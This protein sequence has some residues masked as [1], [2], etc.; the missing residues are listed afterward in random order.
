LSTS[1]V[2]LVPMMEAVRA[3]TC[4]S[5]VSFSYRHTIKNSSLDAPDSA[6][7]R[8]S[9]P[10][11]PRP[12]SWKLTRLM[13]RGTSSAPLAG[14]INTAF[15][16]AARLSPTVVRVCLRELRRPPLA[17]LS[18]ALCEKR[19]ILREPL[20]SSL[21]PP[22]AAASLGDALEEKSDMVRVTPSATARVNEVSLASAT[23]PLPLPPPRLLLLLLLLE[24][25]SEE[26]VDPRRS[27]ATPSALALMLLLKLLLMLKS[28]SGWCGGRDVERRRMRERNRLD[29]SRT[30]YMQV[31]LCRTCRRCWPR[32]P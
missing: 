14:A 9:A 29:I 27:G 2:K 12:S 18:F 11:A 16:A 15:L 4:S 22:P 5:E 25:K 20:R 24:R 1:A 10:A 26:A 17:P 32:R 28:Q 23:L 30:Q 7:F 6:P 19:D 13:D 21:P 3:I 31:A 8:R